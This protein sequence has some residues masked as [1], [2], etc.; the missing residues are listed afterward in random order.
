[1]RWLPLSEDEI[2]SEIGGLDV[3]EQVHLIRSFLSEH[4]KTAREQ[5]VD[6]REGLQAEVIAYSVLDSL[7]SLSLADEK[8]LRGGGARIRR[9][10]EEFSGHP[11]LL[12]YSVPALMQAL[13]QSPSCQLG[14]LRSHCSDLFNHHWQPGYLPTINNDI[15]E[16]AVRDLIGGDNLEVS[17]R[18]Y[19]KI[20]LSQ[21]KLS[22]MLASKRNALTHQLIRKGLSSSRIADKPHYICCFNGDDAINC[23]DKWNLVIPASYLLDLCDA[24]LESSCTYLIENQIA[25]YPMLMRKAAWLAE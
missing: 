1:M 19:P 17:I 22:R 5:L 24:G 11:E 25:P 2:S 18:E 6:N 3:A 14:K 12:N 13:G 15:C 9:Y 10:I 20:T 4:I 23:P 8:H 21:C 16:E 7:G